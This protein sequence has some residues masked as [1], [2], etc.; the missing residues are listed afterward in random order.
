MSDRP[1]F[2]P[3]YPMI[4]NNISLGMAQQIAQ[5]QQSRQAGLGGVGNPDNQQLWQNMQQNF[6]HAQGSG[7]NVG[8]SINPQVQSLPLFI[9]SRRRP[10]DDDDAST[11]QRA[12]TPDRP[13]VVLRPQYFHIWE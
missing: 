5:Q 13:K 10:L 12:R 6:R 2:M 1:N 11:R 8:Q 7:D 4:P 3:G 9:L